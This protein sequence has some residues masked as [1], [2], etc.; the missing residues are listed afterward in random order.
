M[1]RCG[2]DTVQ[3]VR[4]PGARQQQPLVHDLH[5]VRLVGRIQHHDPRG[6][7]V[8]GKRGIV[9]GDVARQVIRLERP[10]IGGS[11]SGLPCQRA[12][13]GGQ[14]IDVARRLLAVSGVQRKR[15]Q[16]VVPDPVQVFTAAGA[17]ALERHRHQVAAAIVVVG[18]VQGLVKVSDQVHHPLQRLVA[19]AR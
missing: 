2:Q 6:H 14:G 10:A 1:S 3:K 11:V 13:L 12:R 9:I 16:I 17:H 7:S 4:Q 15:D 18:G 5:G 8:A 19:L